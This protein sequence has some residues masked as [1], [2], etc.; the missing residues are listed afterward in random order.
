MPNRDLAQSERDAR[1]QSLLARRAHRRD[2]SPSVLRRYPKRQPSITDE[3]DF[4]R[5]FKGARYDI[6][7]APDDVQ[8]C[9]FDLRWR[10]KLLFDSLFE[11][12]RSDTPFGSDRVVFDSVDRPSSRPA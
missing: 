4:Q 9:L 6:D 3:E 12:G 10:G 8:D 5:A 1:W 2:G 11:T 7:N